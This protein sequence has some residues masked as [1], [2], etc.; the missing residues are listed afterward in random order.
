MDAFYASIEIRDRPELRGKPVA[1]GGSREARGV[2]A[3]ASYAARGFGVHSA[4]PTVTAL[5]LCPELILLPPR[6][7]VY[8]QVSLRIHEIFA[9]YT[10]EIEPLALDEAFLDVTASERLFGGA[11]VIGES[12]KRQIRD[13]LGLTASVGIARNKYVAKVASDLRKP[14]ALVYVEPGSET[15]FLDPLPISRLWGIGKVS[16]ARYKMFS[17]N[18]IKQV[19]EADPEWLRREFGNSGY[20]AWLLANGIDNRKV[21][22]ESKARSISHETTFATDIDDTDLL[23][24]KLLEFS[25]AVAYR[26][27]QAGLRGRTVY[28]KVRL[29]DFSTYTR[30]ATLPSATDS[31]DT[32]WQQC[33]SLLRAFRR[34]KRGAVRLI[35][36]GVSGLD[37]ENVQTE[38]FDEIATQHSPIDEV[39]DE[40]KQRFGKSMIKRGRS[41]R[42][43][44]KR[45]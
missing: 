44:G 30:S 17:L 15:E 33:Q 26:L 12:I 27:R 16:E 7:H 18:T 42:A 10:P 11:R 13:E 21:I 40:I 22:S 34:G 19:R 43:P 31:T 9:R 32:L 37:E 4:L 1:V 35:G 23:R 29:G 2:I 45:V 20:A 25:E 24:A 5:R 38:L 36:M 14:D 8:A 39:A 28:L 6:M 41:S 3:A